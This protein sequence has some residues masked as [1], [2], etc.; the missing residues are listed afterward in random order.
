MNRHF[1]AKFAKREHWHIIETASI[2]IKF[3]ITMK[4]TKG[5]AEFAGVENAG[6]EIS[7][8]EK[9]GKAKR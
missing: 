3:C 4:A 6:V 5:D 8:E 7:G 2:P 1:Q 9:V